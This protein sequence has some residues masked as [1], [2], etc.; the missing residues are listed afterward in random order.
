M[1]IGN[2]KSLRT[3][4]CVT[5]SRRRDRVA[6]EHFL[7]GKSL[8]A[9]LFSVV[10][11]GLV[12][13][14]WPFS[15]TLPVWIY[16]LFVMAQSGI[17]W[18]QIRRG[19]L[20]CAALGFC[21]TAMLLIGVSISETWRPWELNGYLAVWLL[22]PP[23]TSLA[24]R[25]LLLTSCLYYAIAVPLAPLQSWNWKVADRL[26]RRVARFATPLLLVSSAVLSFLTRQ[27]ALVTSVPY[28]A[29]AAVD[30]GI[31]SSNSGLKLLAPMLLSFCLVAAYRGYGLSNWRYRW[32]LIYTL[33]IAV[34]FSLMRGTRVGIL[35]VVMTALLL[36]YLGSKVS[37]AKKFFRMTIVAVSTFLLLQVWS[38]ARS[39]AAHIGLLPAMAQG[40][41]YKVVPLLERFDPLQVQLL[42]QSY[43]HLLDVEFLVAKGLSIHG[44]TVYGLLPQ[45]IP[46]VV[47]RVF[48][49]DR[50]LN[51]AWL[52]GRYGLSSGG[53]MYIVAEGY[54]N[55]G[56][57]GAL[58]VAASMA[59]IAV[60]LERWYR[61]QEPL[62]AWTYFAF[63]S[64]LAFGMFYGL[65]PFTKA[66]EVSLVL[67]LCTRL[68]MNSF[69][70]SLKHRP[71]ASHP[72]YSQV[73]A[74]GG[75]PAE[76][77]G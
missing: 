47:A 64:S 31:L 52:V 20:L 2:R 15:G 53:G 28:P 74:L 72:V 50:P 54:W 23:L 5:R 58:G 68:A 66:L 71:P 75:R 14:I 55:F 6:G 17:L 1:L 26:E 69:R 45:S 76:P 73:R 40:W 65:Q 42:P 70:K 10:L 46:E 44:A 19:N 7:K 33:A 36:F 48:H 3:E 27:G 8:E 35:F 30:P 22:K 12:L 60:G 18:E 77:L 32:S 57:F 4:G 39:V 16:Y 67:A 41:N 61:R 13:G 59:L 34:Y 25:I 49:L 62:L 37:P 63:L 51:S 56:M 29:N 38:Q 11:A 24:N 21:L 43:W 9:I